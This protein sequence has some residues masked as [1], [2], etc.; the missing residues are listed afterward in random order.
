MFYPTLLPKAQL[1][2]Q[3]EVFDKGENFTVVVFLPSHNHRHDARGGA[4]LPGKPLF[5]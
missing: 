3:G 1:C 4:S 2:M 5:T